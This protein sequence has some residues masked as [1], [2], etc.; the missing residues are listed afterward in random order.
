MVTEAAETA[1][2]YLPGPGSTSATGALSSRCLRAR[3]SHQR[4]HAGD[5]VVSFEAREPTVD[6]VRNT[7]QCDRRLGDVGGHNNLSAGAT[8]AVEDA[9][10]IVLGQCP[11]QRQHAQR[12]VGGVEGALVLCGGHGRLIGSLLA[13]AILLNQ[14]THQLL[15]F[16]LT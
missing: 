12:G 13:V 16:I 4:L 15:Y 10:L 7:R 2:P 9:E 6:H 1:T 5:W 8:G 14:V 11:V 3:H